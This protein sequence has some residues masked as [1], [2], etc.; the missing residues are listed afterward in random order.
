MNGT[1]QNQK[2]PDQHKKKIR[3][4]LVD[5]EAINIEREAGSGIWHVVIRHD[6]VEKKSEQKEINL[7]GTKRARN[8][9]L[10]L[11]QFKTV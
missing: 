1:Q 4:D 6:A 2:H 10:C 3:I 9:E 11:D 7:A 8:R 5:D